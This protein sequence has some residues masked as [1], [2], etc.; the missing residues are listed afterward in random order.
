M[1]TT[2]LNN[3]P[4]RTAG[5]N[6]IVPEYP[7]TRL[8]DGTLAVAS[9]VLRRAHRSIANAICGRPGA[10]TPEEFSFLC[11]L[12]DVSYA[13]VAQVVDVDRSTITKWIERGKPWGASRSNLVKRWFYAGLFESELRNLQIPGALAADDGAILRLIHDAVLRSRGAF[14]VAGP[15]EQAAPVPAEPVGFGTAAPV[16]PPVLRHVPREL[17]ERARAARHAA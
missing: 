13:A 3:H 9:T 15:G 10:M 4:L 11:D 12:A 2:V 5:H 8:P 6:W 7:V 16:D 14:P 1:E 17:R